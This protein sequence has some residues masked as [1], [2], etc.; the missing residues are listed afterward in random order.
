MFIGVG[1]NLQN[2]PPL[3][4]KLDGFPVN[5]TRFGNL[6]SCTR[7]EFA[8]ILFGD[9]LEVTEDMV[10]RKQAELDLVAC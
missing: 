2:V 8:G 9:G 6:V 4:R 5:F 1:V 10:L 3:G 7:K